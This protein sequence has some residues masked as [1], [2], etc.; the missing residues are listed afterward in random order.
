MGKHDVKNHNGAKRSRARRNRVDPLGDDYAT[1]NFTQTIEPKY[2]RRARTKLQKRQAAYD[3]L[4]TEKQRART[5][6][7][8]MK[9]RT[10]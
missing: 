7:G 4:S 3:A 1:T 2:K 9:T 6:P 8:S 10:N 5:R